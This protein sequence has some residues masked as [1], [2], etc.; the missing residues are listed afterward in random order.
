[1][2]AKLKAKWLVFW[3]NHVQKT[4]GG[5]LVGLS[6]IDLASS[7]TGYQTDI[8]TLIGQ[9]WYAATRMI[10]AGIVVLRAVAV[11]KAMEDAMKSVAKPTDPPPPAA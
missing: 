2:F 10:A 4:F 8:T 9:K 6:G 11:K 5:L 1:M 7:L 3:R